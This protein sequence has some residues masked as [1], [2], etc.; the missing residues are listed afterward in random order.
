MKGTSAAAAAQA[1]AGVLC[2]V[3]IALCY[4]A[5]ICYRT[6]K[7]RFPTNTLRTGSYSILLLL[8]ISAAAPFAAAVDGGA[9]R[10]TRM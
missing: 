1:I 7:S 9:A 8:P 2:D 3:T 10:S 4:A 6:L 5:A